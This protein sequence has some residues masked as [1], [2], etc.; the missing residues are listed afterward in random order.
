MTGARKYPPT[1]LTFWIATIVA[2]IVAQAG[3]SA[4]LE[5]LGEGWRTADIATVFGT[6]IAVAAHL[7]VP[8]YVAA[9]YWSAFVLMSATSATASS[10]LIRAAGATH[11][12]TLLVGL[13]L[14]TRGLFWVAFVLTRPLVASPSI[15]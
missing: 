8:R 4:L 15:C 13:V 11:G 6:V 9:L 3:R 10:A 1:T 12:A 5:P 7:L 2:A 14:I